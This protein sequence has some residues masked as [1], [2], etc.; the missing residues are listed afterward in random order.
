T[1]EKN[2]CGPWG[3]SVIVPIYFNSGISNHQ[4]FALLLKDLGKKDV[5]Q[6]IV[7]EWKEAKKQNNDQKLRELSQL[8]E[9]E[10]LSR[11]NDFQSAIERR[12][13]GGDLDFGDSE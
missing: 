7:K 4:A 3:S 11:W 12:S 6:T 5:V 10:A 8:L 2:K 1:I 9:K 13:S